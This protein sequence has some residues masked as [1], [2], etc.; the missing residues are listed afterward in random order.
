MFICPMI[1]AILRILYIFKKPKIFRVLTTVVE[2]PN[3]YAIESRGNV[4]KIS[5]KKG[6]AHM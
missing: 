1:L 2:A 3:G 6:P 4:E 5:M